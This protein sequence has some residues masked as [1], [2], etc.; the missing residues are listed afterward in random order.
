[1]YIAPVDGQQVACCYPGIT[2]PEPV[3]KVIAK[4]GGVKQHIGED[5]SGWVTKQPKVDTGLHK[6]PGK[7]ILTDI[8]KQGL[9]LVHPKP[10]GPLV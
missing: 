10:A 1:M 5:P 2:G 3:S 4:G 7:K 6:Y 8:K 9:R